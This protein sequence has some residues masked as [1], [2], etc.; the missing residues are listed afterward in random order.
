MRNQRATLI[1][2]SG[3]SAK[4]EVGVFLE[5]LFAGK[6]DELYLLLWRLPEKS[7]HWSRS[8]KDAIRYAESFK[9]HDLYIGVG[10]STKDQGPKRRCPSEEVAGLVGVYADIDLRSDAHAKGNLPATV[11]QALSIL[12][13]EFSPTLDVFSGERDHI[14]DAQAGVSH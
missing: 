14:A 4:V 7:S 5:S 10:L 11:E 3:P 2:P 13:S 9:S 12:P 1:I 8:I 6:P